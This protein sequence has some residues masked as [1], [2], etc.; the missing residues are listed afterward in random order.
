MNEKAANQPANINLKLNRVDYSARTYANKYVAE[1][2]YTK[3]DLKFLMQYLNVHR[4]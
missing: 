1:L 4:L 3:L 2:S